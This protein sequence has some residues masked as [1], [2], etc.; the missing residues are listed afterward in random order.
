MSEDTRRGL[1][2]A[3][4]QLSTNRHQH[5]YGIGSGSEKLLDDDVEEDSEELESDPDSELKPSAS[6]QSPS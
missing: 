4:A 5:R 1:E 6:D 3:Y 2:A